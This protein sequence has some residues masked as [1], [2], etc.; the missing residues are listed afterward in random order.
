M[1]DR[2]NGRLD[3]AWLEFT[4]AELRELAAGAP[5]RLVELV[6]ALQ[7]Q[8]RELRQ[9]LQDLQE[10]LAKNSS[11]SNK[12]PGS[13]G[14]GKAP[15]PKNLRAKTDRPAG[16]QPGHPGHTLQ[17]TP[18]PDR[19]VTHGLTFC[20]CGRCAGASLAR[21]P[22]IGYEKRQVFDLPPVRLEVTEHRAEIKRCPVSGCEVRAP[23]PKP[24][25][26]PVQY[27][28][29]FRA[30][31]VYLNQQ[32][33]LPFARIG[34]FCEDLFGQPLSLATLLDANRDAYAALAGFEAQVKEQLCREPV[35]CVD[36]SGLRVAGCLHWVHSAGTAE[37]T[38]YFVHPKR[39]TEAMDAANILPRITGWMVHDFWK[40]YLSYEGPH[41][42]CNQHLLREL[43]F[44]FE[45][46][47]QAWA[48]KM[49]T[50]LKEFHVLC[51]A[52]TAPG[53]DLIEECFRRYH[54]LIQ[55]AR[56]LHPRREEQ[57]GRAKQSKACNLLERLEDY[58]QCV[59]AFLG[60]P[61]VPFTNNQAEQD[62]R[63]VKV[64]QKI[65]GCFRTLEGARIFARVRGFCSTAR[66]QG[67]QLMKSLV[68]ALRGEPFVPAPVP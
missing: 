65:S 19:T 47:K 13:D 14:L 9:Q 39:G 40:P 29:Q 59:L 48:G 38:H 62:I 6:L 28:P 64:K 26:A 3:G 5:E 44:L 66:K 31:L 30:L 68:E 43:K 15:A 41:A 57:A 16:G 37:L 67:R 42:L 34:E 60:D 50:L 45:E 1:G 54:D 63:M 10:R 51:L 33:L 20:P 36:E 61:L 11:N 8:V 53:A 49:I 7:G 23:F 27:G 46:Q 32:Q 12:P 52:P 21:Q 2:R 22:V 56:L 17:R 4:G 18:T 55:E 35:V 25:V 24:V 58:D